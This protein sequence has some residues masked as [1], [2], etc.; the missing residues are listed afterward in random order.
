[1]SKTIPYLSSFVNHSRSKQTNKTGRSADG[2]ACATTPVSNTGAG[3]H[4]PIVSAGIDHLSVTIPSYPKNRVTDIAGIQELIMECTG[5][6]FLPEVKHFN[7]GFEGVV[8][9]NGLTMKWATPG[10]IISERFIFLVIPGGLCGEMDLGL[11]QDL[12]RRIQT[13]KGYCTRIDFQTTVENPEI[14]MEEI[15]QEFFDNNW[16]SKSHTF[17][18][19]IGK[20]RSLKS[21]GFTINVGSRE[22]ESFIRIYD[23]GLEKKTHEANKKIRFEVELKGEMA[24][25]AF[26][27]FCEQKTENCANFSRGAFLSR[28]DFRDVKNAR[29]K[30]SN[31]AQRKEWYSKIFQTEPVKWSI[32]AVKKTIERVKGWIFDSVAPCL[33]TVY[34]ALGVKEGDD[35]IARVLRNGDARMGARHFALLRQ[36]N[37]AYRERNSLLDNPGGNQVGFQS[38]TG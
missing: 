15:L 38:S 21:K 29:G 18:F 30:R 23:K 4:T 37:C 26:R 19:H 36:S 16:V 3:L 8:S 6:E 14:T 31:N 1:M 24:K 35:F 13:L 20:T 9:V 5:E 7:G 12:C 27:Q 22:A 25:D 10:S 2:K 34:E 28:L 32:E 17:D 33:A 11:M